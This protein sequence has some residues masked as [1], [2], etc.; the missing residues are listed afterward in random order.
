MERKFEGRH[1]SVTGRYI[2]KAVRAVDVKPNLAVGVDKTK[3]RSQAPT[4]EG[5]RQGSEVLESGSAIP[6]GFS[7][8]KP[9]HTHY[10]GS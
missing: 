9:H 2:N 10:A 1:P 5:K 4:S 3:P 6:K 7:L 8:N